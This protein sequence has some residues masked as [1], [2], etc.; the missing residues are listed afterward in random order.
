[1]IPL[2]GSLTT[3]EKKT[4]WLCVHVAWHVVPEVELSAENKQQEILLIFKFHAL[5][6]HIYI[7]AISV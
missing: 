5:I 3:D 1:M 4:K 6:I 7:A 2:I